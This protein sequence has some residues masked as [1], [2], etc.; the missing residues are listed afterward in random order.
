ML[1]TQDSAVAGRFGCDDVALFQGILIAQQQIYSANEEIL[2]VVYVT[3]TRQK[4]HYS[5]GMNSC[6]AVPTM[7]RKN[8]ACSLSFSFSLQC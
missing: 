5:C 7:S 3:R 6:I 4:K 2:A 8:H 1:F